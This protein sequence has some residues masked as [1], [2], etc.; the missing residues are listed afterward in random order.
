ME[1]LKVNQ[2]TSLNRRM[3]SQN[4]FLIFFLDSSENQRVKTTVMR[5]HSAAM[6]KKFIFKDDLITRRITNI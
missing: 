4:V 2:I 5:K 1:S 6:K 3:G